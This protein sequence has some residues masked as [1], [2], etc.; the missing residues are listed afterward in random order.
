MCG[1][2]GIILPPGQVERQQQAASDIRSMTNSLAHRG[3]DGE[4]FWTH[5]QHQVFLGHRRLAIIDLSPAGAQPMH[6]LNRYSIVYNGEI[7][8]YIELRDELKS[9]GI[10]F[11]TQSDT[12]VLLA[13]FAHWGLQC[14]DK[15]DGMFAF[16]IWD[17][18]TQTLTLARD[19]FGQKPL[20]YCRDTD[21]RF[22]FAS[23]M[24]AFW[25]IGFP[26]K[27]EAQAML[28]FLATGK[29][30][31]LLSPEN[32]FYENIFQVPAAHV[33]QYQPHKNE[34]TISRYWDLDRQAVFNGDAAQAIAQF[35][36]AFQQSVDK[37]LRADV[38]CGSSLSG[39][40]DSGSI[41]YAISR[42][43]GS[44]YHCFSAI[45]PGFE[46]D[47]SVLISEL[48]AYL[49]ICSHTIQPNEETLAGDLAQMLYHQ[50]EPVGSASVFA[51][52]QVFKLAKEKGIKV[53]LDGQGAD[54]LL[55]GY[56]TSV[57]WFL[58]S[59]WRS[60]QWKNFQHEK[61]AFRRYGWS[62]PYGFR[63]QVAALFPAAAQS[64]LERRERQRIQHLPYVSEDRKAAFP[65][66]LIEKPLVLHLNDLLYDELTRSRLPELL[67]YADRNSMAFGR[68][69]RLPFLNNSIATLAFSLP[70]TLK[71]KEGFRK[72]V[73]RASMD[74]K[75]PAAI[76]W[77]RGKTGFEPP[78]S[79]WMQSP[80]MRDRLREARK[81]LVADGFLEPAVLNAPLSPAAAYDRENADWRQL[82]LA[83]L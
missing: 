55:G 53:L 67:R 79:Q 51:Q 18:Q 62:Q 80:A 3:P 74:Q 45:F 14:L 81:K 57:G 76:V 82:V 19:R 50:E 15:L 31:S 37:S 68:E 11:H 10:H 8:N 59:L 83:S 56:D 22:M 35:S 9:A 48:A 69:V 1:I 25:Q 70:P 39:G 46:K 40:I 78:Q 42:R 32:S 54:E 29:A 12:E 64:T 20:Y 49:G 27:P 26:K 41:A 4:G 36:E 75:L 44:N 13:A 72:W 71:L 73:L 5:P 16:A 60:G 66:E 52:Y 30:Q 34:L 28:Y 23:E 33:L 65:S 2:A 17:E 61:R 24:K 21:H 7:Y 47:E 38:A 43:L 63:N 58:Q 77:Q 6:A